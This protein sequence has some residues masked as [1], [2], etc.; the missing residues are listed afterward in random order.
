[1]LKVSEIM[2]LDVVTMTVH[3]TVS[4]ARQAMAEYN[5]RHI[6][7]VDEKGALIGIV[8]HRDLLKAEVSSLGVA[9]SENKRAIEASTSLSVIMSKTVKSASPHDSLKGAGLQMQASKI[10][11]LPVVED[12]LVVGI[13]TDS[14]FVG[15]AISLIE[16]LDQFENEAVAEPAAG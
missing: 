11:C 2:T 4:Q 10:G 14:D 8:T 9:D 3:D 5:F 15:A 6:P 1:M 13:L 7:I 12:G 16:E